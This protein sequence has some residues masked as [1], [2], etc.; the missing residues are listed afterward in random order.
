MLKR[1]QKEM[2]ASDLRPAKDFANLAERAKEQFIY[3]PETGK[4]KYR[5][6]PNKN[7]DINKEP[8]YINNN[9]YRVIAMD[10]KDYLAHRLVWLYMNNCLPLLI[11][12]I[13]GNKSDNRLCNLR[14]ATKSQ[15]AVN[16]GVRKNN[17]LGIKGIQQ[18]KGSIGYQVRFYING[19]QHYLGTYPTM[20]HALKIY[21]DAV[22]AIHN[23]FV[24]SSVK[25][26]E[27]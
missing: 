18:V 3:D 19:K 15:N 13:N 14:E 8:G 26:N 22:I 24:H 7:I 2:R 21:K 23:E 5:I 25:G 1:E 10:G 12:H 11:D 6:K 4:F 20:D 16:S 27:Q 17:K 9:G